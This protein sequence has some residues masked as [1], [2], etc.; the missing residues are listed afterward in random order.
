MKNPF[1]TKKK[2][3][4]VPVRSVVNSNGSN[5]ISGPISGI[6]SSLS[7]VVIS[8]SPYYYGVQG[9]TGIQGTTGA[10]GWGYASASTFTYMDPDEVTKRRKE[11][12]MREFEENPELFSE[13]IVELRQRK[14]RQLKEKSTPQP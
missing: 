4:V 10:S 7:T 12:L 6:P 9:I 8:S 11:Q 14:I 2:K 1:A 13:I 3:S 5:T